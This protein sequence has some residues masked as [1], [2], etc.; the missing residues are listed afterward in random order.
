[1]ILA[2]QRLHRHLRGPS[3]PG[4]AEEGP[5]A[6]RVPRPGELAARLGPRSGSAGTAARSRTITPWISEVSR[7]ALRTGADEWKNL[8]LAI[9]KPFS[10]AA[11]Y[12]RLSRPASSR[13]CAN[14]TAA[15][16]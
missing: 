10:G 2:P 6:S 16:P 4:H 8:S 12:S 7:A 13:F 14:A 5:N 11:N 3:P 15:D 1:M 9:D